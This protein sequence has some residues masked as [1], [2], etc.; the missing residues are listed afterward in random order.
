MRIA[1]P[2]LVKKWVRSGIVAGQERATIEGEPVSMTVITGP[3][4]LEVVR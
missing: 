2:L 1:P 3:A 4:A